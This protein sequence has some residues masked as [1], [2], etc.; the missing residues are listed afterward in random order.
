MTKGLVMADR[1]RNGMR[2]II[3]KQDR[4]THTRDKAA[5]M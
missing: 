4:G 5:E 1:P 3:V 2:E